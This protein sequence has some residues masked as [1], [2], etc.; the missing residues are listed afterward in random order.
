M[1]FALVLFCLVAF[2]SLTEAEES[3]KDYVLNLGARIY[4]GRQLARSMAIL[5]EKFQVEGV[6]KRSEEAMDGALYGP[7]GW[8]WADLEAA[9]GK[10]GII[11]DC[12]EQPCTINVLLSYC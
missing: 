6:G 10:R 2:W 11:E 8:R 3:M 9:R 12:C 7:R 1:K 5:C 4:C